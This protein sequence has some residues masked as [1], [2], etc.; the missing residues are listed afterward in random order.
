MATQAIR[1]T[2][3]PTLQTLQLAPRSKLLRGSISNYQTRLC[4]REW[5]SE[6]RWEYIK[7]RKGDANMEQIAVL[8]FEQDEAG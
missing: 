1:L 3:R 8:V 4:W 7:E 2:G 5:F 6:L